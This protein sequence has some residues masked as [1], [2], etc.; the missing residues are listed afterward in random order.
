MSDY[1]FDD[2]DEPVRDTR[3][4]RPGTAKPSK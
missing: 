1:D 2:F 4:A 3:H